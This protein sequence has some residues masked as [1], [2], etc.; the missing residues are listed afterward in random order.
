MIDPAAFGRD[1]L[2][3]RARMTPGRLAML[4]GGY[5][6]S[7]AELDERADSLA[8]A[9]VARG[10]GEGD[11]IALLMPNSSRFVELVHASPRAGAI[12]VPLNARLSRDELAWQLRDAAAALLVYDDAMATAARAVSEATGVTAVH[13]GELTESVG[14]KVALWYEYA[15][16]QVHSII[17]TS[18]TTGTPKG[19]MLTFGNHASSAGA[20]AANLGVRDDDRLLA[21]LP[22]FHVGGLAVLL[23]GVLCGNAVVVQESFDPARINA[24]I[25]GDGVTTISVVANMLRRMLD[26]RGDAPYPP[27]LRTVLLGGGPAPR[28]LL[29]ECARRGMPVLQTYGLTEAASQVTTLAPGDARRKLGS[30]GRPLAGTSVRIESDGAPCPE[31]EPGE[32]L[33]RGPTVSPGYW[34]RPDETMAT[35][36][37]GWLRTGD[38]GYLDEEGYLYVLDRRDDLI[39]SGG[40]N[41]YP[42]E[43]ESVLQSHPGVAEA[44]VYGF[45]DARW[46]T[47]PAAAV[48]LR[49]RACAT[50]VQLI[51]WCR[52]HL[53]R[54]KAPTRVSFVD[55]LPRNAGG[56][57]QRR[58]LRER[59]G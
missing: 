37:G 4:A 15:L 6:T 44:G 45:A 21:S 17:Y 54:Y 22:M 50:E 34:N 24:A 55:S 2:R 9:I 8:R 29:E 42:A 14:G 12:V 36:R 27:T 48:V 25:D 35:F 18:G 19:A 3:A 57:L 43:V 11:R 20:S 16:D 59:G 26:E 5:A 33:V 31:C 56:K 28:E 46:G 7:F 41:V 13:A 47:V 58:R 10:V 30:A 38:V 53:A 1:W 40:E 49:D 51:E 52:E 39:V 23:R 32:I